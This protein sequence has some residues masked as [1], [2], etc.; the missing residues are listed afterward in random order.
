MI[1][2]HSILSVTEAAKELGVTDA[3]IRQLCL[4][5]TLNG[6]WKLSARAWLIPTVALRGVRTR[7]Q[8]TD[9]NKKR[10]SLTN[11]ASTK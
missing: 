9:Y 11:G 6:A 4:D 7:K 1:G 10:R 3:R 8:R 2:K 5:G